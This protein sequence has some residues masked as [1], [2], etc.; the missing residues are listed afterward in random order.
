M[1]KGW[2]SYIEP[3][4]PDCEG[5]FRALLGYSTVTRVGATTRTIPAM[6]GAAGRLFSAPLA[7]MIAWVMFVQM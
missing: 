4:L 7:T 1:I 2:L 3:T 5:S 6:S